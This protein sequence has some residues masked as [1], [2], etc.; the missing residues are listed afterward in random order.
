MASAFF[1]FFPDRHTRRSRITGD[2]NENVQKFG[3]LRYKLHYLDSRPGFLSFSS[4]IDRRYTKCNKITTE[5][6]KIYENLS[7]YGTDYIT[8]T[9]NVAAPF[10]TFLFS[11][12]EGRHVKWNKTIA[13]GE[14]GWKKIKISERI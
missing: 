8:L 7:P 4:G 14:K 10:F 12:I 9:K 3:P 11:G 13:K 5:G 6:N 1:F 2:G